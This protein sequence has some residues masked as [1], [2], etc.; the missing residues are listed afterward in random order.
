MYDR[1]K[2]GNYC[3]CEQSHGHRAYPRRRIPSNSIVPV[4]SPST[5]PSVLQARF[6]PSPSMRGPH[7]YPRQDAVATSYYPSEE[8]ADSPYH[9]EGHAVDNPYCTRHD[10][11]GRVENPEPRSLQGGSE[12]GFS[13][14]AGDERMDYRP[15]YATS[16][17]ASVEGESPYGTTVRAGRARSRG[18]LRT[19]DV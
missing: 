5:A 13:W 12:L 15:P 6:S 8:R 16:A 9:A 10:G 17:P 1:Y 19:R 7:R 3:K 11:L 18:S 14:V 4:L 2:H